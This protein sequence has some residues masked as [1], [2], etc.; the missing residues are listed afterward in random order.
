MQDARD[1]EEWR[2]F[3]SKFGH[4]TSCTVALDNEEL[5][6]ALVK[7]RQ[8]Y[9]Q[10]ESLQP[11]GVSVD[12]H[13]DVS[14]AVA[15]A[16][17]VPWYYKL[18]GTMDA[19]TL[20]TEIEKVNTLIETDLAL[21]DYDVSNVFVIFETEYAQQQALKQL[22][23]LGID[24]FRNNTNALPSHL[25]FRGNKVLA[26]KEPPEP[27]SVRWKDLDETVLKQLT[28][29]CVTNFF[30]LL[31]ILASCVI[32][33]YIRYKHGIIYAAVAISVCQV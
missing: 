2:D 31:I 9:V 17:P 20:Q 12:R 8:F 14:I 26:V 18:I 21:R 6:A 29:R 33:T 3:F 7:R 32:V 11:A 10:L 13:A 22:A 19:Q 25:L 23:C 4:V 16:E 28:Q 1:I 30:T 15:T 5:V 27:S 24:K